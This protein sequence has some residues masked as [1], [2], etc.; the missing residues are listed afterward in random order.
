[1]GEEV[2]LQQCEG[3]YVLEMNFRGD[4]SQLQ[5]LYHRIGMF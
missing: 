4:E 3:E 1:M 2:F 5:M